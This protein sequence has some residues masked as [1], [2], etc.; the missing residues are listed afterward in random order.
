[1][2]SGSYDAE[3]LAEGQPDTPGNREAALSL[4]AS[5]D[6]F[7]T[8]GIQ[9]VRGRPFTDADTR[10]STPVAI[11]DQTMA[12]KLWPNENPI[13]RRVQLDPPVGGAP[14]WREVVG[15]VRNIHYYRLERAARITAYRPVTQA[16]YDGAP[17]FFLFVKTRGDAQALS[18]RIRQVVTTADAGTAVYYVQT[19]DD[20]VNQYLA[21]VH[22]LE[23][24]LG[25]FAGLALMLA[26]LGAYGLIAYTVARRT[27]ELGIRM[28]LGATSAQAA[29]LVMRRGFAMTGVGIGAGLVGAAF[30][31]RALGA[32][33]FGVKALDPA[34]YIAAS[35]CLAGVALA[36][37]WI[38]ARRVTRIPPG[39]ALRAE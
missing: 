22:L 6:L 11:I 13:G 15:V 37:C 9:L 38:P 28:A 31:S 30:A 4:N 24:L 25:I 32:S 10:T 39:I 21:T 20:V 14:Q 1:L 8:M 18:A 27:R 19:M 36:A 17:N 16:A 26:A 3:V 5:P 33:L 12:E 2:F 34:V 35:A 23:Q 7:R 29:R